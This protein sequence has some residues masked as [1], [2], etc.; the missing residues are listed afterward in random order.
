[1]AKENQSISQFLDLSQFA[2]PEPL[3]WRDCQVPL[4]KDL[5]KIHKSYYQPFSSPFPE[6]PT[7]F[8]KVNCTLEERRQSHFPV[9][10]RCWL[11]TDT[12]S[13]RPQEA[14]PPSNYSRALW[15]PGDEWIFAWSLTHSRYNTSLNSSFGYFPSPRCIIEI[16]SLRS[17]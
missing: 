12:D 3:E 14:L 16:D 5:N 4:K 15:R 11:W 7:V 10:I 13:K 17:W 8:H 6:G 2:K 9:P 1:M